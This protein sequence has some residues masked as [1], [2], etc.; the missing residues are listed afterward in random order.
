MIYQINSPTQ[1]GITYLGNGTVTNNSITT[2]FPKQTITLF[3]IQPKPTGAQYDFET[4]TQGW[5]KTGSPIASLA[6]SASQHFSGSKSL[7]VT[8]DGTVGTA[9]AYVPQPT[10]PAGKA[11]TFHV[12]IPANS[13][14]ASIQCYVEQSAAGGWTY[15]YVQ[16]TIAQLTTGAWN[17]ITVNVPQNAVTP[18]YSLGVSFTT[19]GSWTGTCY[20]DSISW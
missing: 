20:I 16:K 3:V 1:S 2:I 13:Q 14:I 8:F 4:G 17:T 6:T 5:T 11:V 10:T 19:S 12:W 9:S 7:A 15:T 18:L